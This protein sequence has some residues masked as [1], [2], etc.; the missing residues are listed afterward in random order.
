MRVLGIGAR[1]AAVP[2]TPRAETGGRRRRPQGTSVPTVLLDCCALCLR[3]RTTFRG[4]EYRRES[5]RRLCRAAAAALSPLN[6]LNPLLVLVL[7]SP[8]RRRTPASRVLACLAYLVR[9]ARGLAADQVGVR[10]MQV[11]LVVQTCTCRVL[12]YTTT[13]CLVRVCTVLYLGTS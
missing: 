8:L 3:W 11:Q 2:A 13:Y 10:H 7:L 9:R 12:L 6:P 5:R 1:S 4:S